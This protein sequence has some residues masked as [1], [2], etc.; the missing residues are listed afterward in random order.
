MMAVIMIN[1]IALAGIIAAAIAVIM[2]AGTFAGLQLS[3]RI[4][5][6]EEAEEFRQIIQARSKYNRLHVVENDAPP[7][8]L[9]RVSAA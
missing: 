8:D 1:G 2:V 5:R 3:S 4:S 6:E 7:E 9:H